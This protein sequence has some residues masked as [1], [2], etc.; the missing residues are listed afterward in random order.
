VPVGVCG[1]AL[2]VLCASSVPSLSSC[3]RA[4]AIDLLLIEYGIVPSVKIRGAFRVG[5]LGGS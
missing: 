1:V 2:V 4:W 5:R 3:S